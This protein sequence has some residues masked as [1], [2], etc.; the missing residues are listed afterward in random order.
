M[1]VGDHPSLDPDTCFVN[2][3]I[4]DG[5]TPDM[6]IAKEEIFGP[7]ASV[8][9]AKDLDEAIEMANRSNFGNAA[10]LHLQW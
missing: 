8:M 5:V 7:V 10:S 4:F 2:P 6:T 3:T 1:M 9:R